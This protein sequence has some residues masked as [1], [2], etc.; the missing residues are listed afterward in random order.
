MSERSPWLASILSEGNSADL[1]FLRTRRDDFLRLGVVVLEEIADA[2]AH[3]PPVL[4][5][6]EALGFLQDLPWRR[7]RRSRTADTPGDDVPY[8]FGDSRQDLRALLV[9][10][11]GF[12]EPEVF[13]RCLACH[14]LAHGSSHQEKWMSNPMRSRKG[15]LPCPAMFSDPAAVPSGSGVKVPAW[16]CRIRIVPRPLGRGCAR[17]G[18]TLC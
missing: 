5:P 14:C 6:V 3:R 9:T 8:L 7:G 13:E 18:R 2:P 12:L 10:E 4:I 1:R 16:G 15:S 11:V 17:L